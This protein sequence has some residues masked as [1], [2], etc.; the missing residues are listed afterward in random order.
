MLANTPWIRPQ[1]S[2]RPSKPSRK[3]RK[4]GR[5]RPPP[6]WF[7]TCGT[8]EQENIRALVSNAQVAYLEDGTIQRQLA[9]IYKLT[10]KQ[11]DEAIDFFQPWVSLGAAAG[12][13]SRSFSIGTRTDVSSLP[14]I[15]TGKQLDYGN[16]SRPMAPLQRRI[17]SPKGPLNAA[18]LGS[19]PKPSSNPPP[20]DGPE[21]K[22]DEPNGA[23][24]P[25]SPAGNNAKMRSAEGPDD[26]VP[27]SS[28]NRRPP[29]GY[30]SYDNR[31]RTDRERERP[32]QDEMGKREPRLPI[33]DEK[34]APLTAQNLLL[35]N[36]MLIPI[37]GDFRASVT[38]WLRKTHGPNPDDPTDG[39]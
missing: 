15:H 24:S 12:G 9:T 34:T 22:D 29:G 4:P 38:N 13:G 1:R 25:P 16:R 8:R 23:K 30:D 3:T 17:A 5:S 31:G 35:H 39:M 36:K 37:K 11:I 20:P 28:Q 18:P 7:L 2:K 19:Y 6:N 33:I 14:S 32:R 26:P 27:A 10:S 21:Q